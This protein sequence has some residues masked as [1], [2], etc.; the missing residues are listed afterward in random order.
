MKSQ[1]LPLWKSIH[2]L[3]TVLKSLSRLWGYAFIFLFDMFILSI[4]EQ[5]CYGSESGY[6][7][8]WISYFKEYTIHSLRRLEFVSFWLSVDEK[9]SEAKIWSSDLKTEFCFGFKISSRY[10]TIS[11]ASFPRRKGFVSVLQRMSLCSWSVVSGAWCSRQHT[12]KRLLQDWRE[13]S[14]GWVAIV[15]WFRRSSTFPPEVW[16]WDFR[17][18]CKAPQLKYGIVGTFEFVN[19]YE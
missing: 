12:L 11:G 1:S 9:Q 19:I 7:W 17:S 14:S 4:W 18:W 13:R 16:Y 3:K 8:W 5:V 2:C 6:V 10:F 15:R